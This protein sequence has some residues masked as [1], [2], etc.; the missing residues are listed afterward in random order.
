[1][2]WDVLSRDVLSYIR[3]KEVFETLRPL[4]TELSHFISF[5]SILL[6]LVTR[7]IN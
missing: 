5:S 1:M 2:V 7:Y 4:F 6:L 3:H